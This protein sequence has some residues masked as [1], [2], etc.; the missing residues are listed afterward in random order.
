MSDAAENQEPEEEEV[1]AEIEEAE[2]DLA[3]V[4]SF[5]GVAVEA[6]EVETFSRQDFSEELDFVRANMLTPDGKPKSIQFRIPVTTGTMKEFGPKGQRGVEE[7]GRERAFKK[8]GAAVGYTMKVDHSYR[9]DGKTVLR[10]KLEERKPLT[11]LGEIKRNL[12]QAARLDRDSHKKEEAGGLKGD[13][14][15][16]LQEKRVKDIARFKAAFNKANGYNA[17]DD[18]IKE[19]LTKVRE[20]NPWQFQ[21]SPK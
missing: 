20:T 17:K 2:E 18:K 14:L 1:E 5:G 9:A 19:M 21:K 15:T 16:A 3:P 7:Y 13:A 11:P 4:I 8:A 6:E 12:S 10:I